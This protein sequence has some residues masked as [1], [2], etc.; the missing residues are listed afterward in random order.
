[1]ILHPEIL[2]CSKRVKYNIHIDTKTEMMTFHVINC[3][4]NKLEY[5]LPI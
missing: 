5:R 3:Q 2:F 4:N 1:M